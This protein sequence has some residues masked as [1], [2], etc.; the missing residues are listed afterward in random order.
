LGLLQLQ[1][2]KVCGSK[3]LFIPP[4]FTLSITNSSGDGQSALLGAELSE[5]I[6][7]QGMK[8]LSENNTHSFVGKWDASNWNNGPI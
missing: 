4:G 1:I 7:V 8:H 2:V 6:E 3:W 5:A